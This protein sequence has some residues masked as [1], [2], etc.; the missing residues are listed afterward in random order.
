MLVDFISDNY[1]YLSEDTFFRQFECSYA[2]YVSPKVKTELSKLLEASKLFSPNHSLGLFPLVPI[3]V[4]LGFTCESFFL[5]E[6]EALTTHLPPGASEW[7]APEAF[8]PLKRW[9]G[10]REKP[11][12]WLGVHSPAIQSSLK[13]KAAILGAVA[14]A[15]PPRYR[16][17]FTHR[18]VFG[19]WCEVGEF[20]TTSL[21]EPHTPA[22]AEDIIITGDDH[23]WLSLLHSKLTASHKDMRRQVRALEYFYKAWPLDP[24]DRFPLLCMTLDAIFG[25]ENH[26]TQSLIDGIRTAI[27]SHVD[28][29]RLRLLIKLRASVI[30]GGAPDVYDSSKYGKYFDKYGQDPIYDLELVA[31]QCLREVIFGGVFK[32]H[33]DTNA[34]LL[35]ELQAMGQLP[36]KLEE[37]TILS[38]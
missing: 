19:G 16:H 36:S 23:S 2:Q 13:M 27:G 22:M 33:K 5:I 20:I 30:H 37:G 25:D 17:M 3:R 29:E 18:R 10:K 4:E 31:A 26:A 9:E 12:S 1:W 8:P 7:F 11:T 24:G 15:P 38:G 21:G 35:T 14:L 32:E 28:E 6:P 34:S